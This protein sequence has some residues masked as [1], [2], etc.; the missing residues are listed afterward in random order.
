LITRKLPGIALSAALLLASGLT[1]SIPATA[2]DGACDAFE[3]YTPLHD[4]SSTVAKL[5]LPAG[6]AKEVHEFANELNAIGYSPS[7]NLLYGVSRQSHVVTISPGGAVV[8]RGKVHDVGDATAGAI[9]GSTLF[10][11][12]GPRLLSLDVNPAS[13]TY[14]KIVK[15]KWL[16]WIA[17]V[18]DFDFGSDAL[19]YGVTGIGA[20]VSIDPLRGTVRTVAKPKVLPRGT[21]GAILMAPGR[22]LYAINNQ[23]GSV[24]KLYRIPLAAPNTASEVAS[25]PAADS[26]DAAGC[27]PAPQVVE[28]PAPPPPAQSSAP[29]PAPR[30]P[31]A[32]APVPPRIPVPIRTPVTTTS[33]SNPPPALVQQPVPPPLVPGPPKSIIRKPLPPSPRPVAAPVRSDT[34]KKRRWAL[35]TLVLVLGAGAV[36]AATTRNR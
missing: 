4:P 11:R 22:I 14:L 33:S 5:A 31:G 32:P 20:V 12:D 16:S 21:Y 19:L 29:A 6:I 28:P 10:L 1:G 2:A 3:V 17:D 8:D 30:S 18:D 34:E 24:S 23:V 13:P 35:T 15:V 26:T 7:Q 36:A 9:S 25:Y 27:L